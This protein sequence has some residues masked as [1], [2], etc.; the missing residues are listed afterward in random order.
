MVL[1]PCCYFIIYTC[2]Y[3]IYL[4]IMVLSWLASCTSIWCLAVLSFRNFHHKGVPMNFSM[5]VIFPPRVSCIKLPPFDIRTE[6]ATTKPLLSLVEG[7]V[8]HGIFLALG[9]QAFAKRCNVRYSNS[10]NS[11]L[12]LFFCGCSTVNYIFVSCYKQGCSVQFRL[13]QGSRN[14]CIRRVENVRLDDL[15]DLFRSVCSITPVPQP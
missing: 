2:F 15:A 13:V 12:S 3:S 9:G 11:F 7:S 14:S 10:G 1:N 5:P 8:A 6:G 4:F